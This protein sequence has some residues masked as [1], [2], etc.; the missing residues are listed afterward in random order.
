MS[1]WHDAVCVLDKDSENHMFVLLQCYI[2]ISNCK[3]ILSLNI[4]DFI[5]C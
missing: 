2:Y 4:E 3:K 5:T 1:S